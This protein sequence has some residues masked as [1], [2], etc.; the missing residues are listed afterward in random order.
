MYTLQ[1]GLEMVAI[2]EIVAASSP[3]R[4]VATIKRGTWLNLLWVLN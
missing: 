1:F 4:S 3:W 2:D